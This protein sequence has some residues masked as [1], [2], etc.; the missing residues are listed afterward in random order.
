MKAAEILAGVEGAAA[1][2]IA[3]YP[4]PMTE[5]ERK[6]FRLG[7]IAGTEHGI[8]VAQKEFAELMPEPRG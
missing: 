4:T 6:F 1:V 5:S 7:F 8:G 3:A 2:A